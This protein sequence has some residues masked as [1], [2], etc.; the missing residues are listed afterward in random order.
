MVQRR[1]GAPLDAF[2]EVLWWSRRSAPYRAC[3]HML[4]TGT[5]QLVLVLHEEPISWARAGAE[6]EPLHRHT[7]R[8][9]VVHGPQTT[10]YR[11]G[12]KPS[13]AVIGA[14]FR[15][16]AA[17]AVLGMPAVALLD[18]HVAI[19]DLWG[20]WGRKLHQCLGESRSAQDALRSL[21]RALVS[22]L[23]ARLQ[24]HAAVAEAL[25]AGLAAKSIEHLR[26]ASGYSH[27]HF[28]ELFRAAVGLT[29]KHYFRIQR[30]AAM[31][32]TIAAEPIKLAEL[33]AC[34]GYA[35]QA[36]LSREFRALSGV[37]PSAY[38]PQSPTS[39]FHH[40]VG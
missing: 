18:Q 25:S 13:G 4:P 28:L 38:R 20:A 35:D 16:G 23:D 24:M 10:Y 37:P 29:P 32:R 7:W 39:P 27:R 2:V 8:R 36:H 12:P 1:P 21:E 31:A 33:A 11:A 19:D 14:S 30:F 15:A 34:G 26:R 6:A 9:G 22:R 3:E 40:V 5:C 17:A